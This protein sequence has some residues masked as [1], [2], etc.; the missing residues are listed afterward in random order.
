MS[1]IGVIA[2]STGSH[3]AS[4]DHANNFTGPKS[5]NRIEG[6]EEAP[7]PPP[8][9]PAEDRPEVRQNLEQGWEHLE[10]VHNARLQSRSELHELVEEINRDNSGKD[11]SIDDLVT[12]ANETAVDLEKK[13]EGGAKNSGDR[14][15]DRGKEEDS[16]PSLTEIIS[17]SGLSLTEVVELGL[18]YKNYVLDS[19]EVLDTSREVFDIAREHPDMAEEIG[20]EHLAE[21]QQFWTQLGYDETSGNGPI[22]VTNWAQRGYHNASYNLETDTIRFGIGATGVP[23]AFASDVVAHEYAH[24]MVHN[25][26]ED[27]H[28]N[29]SVHNQAINESLADTFAAAADGDWSI[30]EDVVAGGD[31]DIALANYT[32]TDYVGDRQAREDGHVGA[33]LPNAAAWRIGESVGREDMARI[34]AETVDHHLGGVTTFRDFA[35]ATYRGAVE[36]FG[37][38]S[39]QAQAVVDSWTAVLELHDGGMN[40]HVSPDEVFTTFDLPTD[41]F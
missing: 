38:D 6:P 16:E 30:G 17:G 4:S 7:P 24:R 36:I 33:A 19:V 23:Y 29:G 15:A 40:D 8:P 25:L 13:G 27:F 41:L 1:I 20:S 18:Q 2:G 14:S 31:R 35:T 10:S 22:T 9:T 3:N 34:Y 12:L 11:I 32:V 37:E 21:A 28:R 26:A 39:A 5:G